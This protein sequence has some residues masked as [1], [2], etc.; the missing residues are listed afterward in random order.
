MMKRNKKYLDHIFALKHF[1][2]KP[3][4][5]VLPIPSEEELKKQAEDKKEKADKE[6]A[7][8]DKEGEDQK[9]GAGKD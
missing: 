2:P 9:T 5:P 4:I 3:R 1:C 6:K 8:K 7:E